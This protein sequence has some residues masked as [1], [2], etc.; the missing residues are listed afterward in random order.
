MKTGNSLTLSL[1]DNAKLAEVFG[2]KQPGDEVPVK[3]GG[4]DGMLVIDELLTDRVSGQI[5]GLGGEDEEATPTTT[6]AGSALGASLMGVM[7]K[8]KP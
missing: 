8:K 1:R 7:A 3:I 6:P 2:S 4:V 5:E